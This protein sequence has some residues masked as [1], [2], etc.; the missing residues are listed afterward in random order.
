MNVA[1]QG[2]VDFAPKISGTFSRS[3]E[4]RRV[5]NASSEIAMPVDSTAECAGPR[6]GLKTVSKLCALSVRPSALLRRPR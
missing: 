5:M 1:E 6:R 3:W 2:A 4:T